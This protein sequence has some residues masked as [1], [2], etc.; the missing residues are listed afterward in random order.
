MIFAERIR[1]LFMDGDVFPPV[2]THGTYL[3]NRRAVT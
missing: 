1:I 2:T 3:M